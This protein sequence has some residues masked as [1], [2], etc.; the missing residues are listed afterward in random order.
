MRYRLIR[1]Y[2]VVLAVLVSTGCSSERGYSSLTAIDGNSDS[3]DSAAAPDSAAA[4]AAEAAIAAAEAAAAAGDAAVFA[5]NAAND[6]AI[7]ATGYG[8]DDV[9]SDDAYDHTNSMP[10]DS[11]SSNCVGSSSL[12]TCTDASGNSYTT[13]RIGDLSYTDGYNSRTGSS[14]SQSTQRI[15]DTSFTTGTD[16]DGNTWNSTTQRIGDT[17]FQHGTNSEGES[18]SSTCNEYGCY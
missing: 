17:T 5:A 6:S 10:S 9:Y 13:Q 14:W 7:A 11:L 16:A 2:L 15:G 1:S 8:E 4:A 3:S 12:R 18:F